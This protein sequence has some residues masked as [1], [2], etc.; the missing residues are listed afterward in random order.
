MIG[1]DF[2]GSKNPTNKLRDQI[3]LF[4]QNLTTEALVTRHCSHVSYPSNQWGGDG[5][6]LNTLELE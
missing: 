6:S 3:L 2:H 4:A 5:P 1:A